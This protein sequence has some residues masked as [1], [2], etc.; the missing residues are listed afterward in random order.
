MPLVTPMYM[1]IV[2]QVKGKYPPTVARSIAINNSS[3]ISELNYKFPAIWL[4]ER[5]LLWCYIHR[6]SLRQWNI[7]FL[8]LIT[9][10]VT[11][12]ISQVNMADSCW[13]I[14][15]FINKTSLDL[16]SSGIFERMEKLFK[17]TSV[18]L[19]EKSFQEIVCK[20]FQKIC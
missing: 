16:I 15:W 4:A 5:S 3:I 13:M 6:A 14:F 9:K 17:M 2:L 20:A 19:D 1:C 7:T 8:S 18:P 10:L 12:L 11:F